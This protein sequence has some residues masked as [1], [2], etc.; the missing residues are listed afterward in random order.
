MALHHDDRYGDILF[1]EHEYYAGKIHFPRESRPAM[2]EW[3]VF[4]Q[5][6]SNLPNMY[7]D[8]Y[9][10]FQA[11]GYDMNDPLRKRENMK[12][13]R[14]TRDRGDGLD[15]SIRPESGYGGMA[16]DV[17]GLLREVG[18]P[19]TLTRV[20]KPLFTGGSMDPW[21][22]QMQPGDEFYWGNVPMFFPY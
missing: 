6:V 1:S 7:G 21:S 22:Y 20:S 8:L 2:H 10:S 9:K 17:W 11:K 12:E 4:N 3:A 5:L 14:T 15:R 16:K 13:P 19:G 18:Q